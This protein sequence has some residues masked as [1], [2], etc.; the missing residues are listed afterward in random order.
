MGMI[1][2]TKSQLET[3]KL[4]KMVVAKLENLKTNGAGVIALEGELGAGKTTLVKGLAKELKIKEKVKSPTFVLVKNYKIPNSEL[5]IRNRI[6]NPKSVI[7]QFKYL[8][9]ID[10]YRLTNYKDLVALGI[11][12][13][14]KEEGSIIAIEW[15]ERVKSI[16]PKKRITVRIDHADKNKRAIIIY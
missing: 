16:L 11:K 9:H 5:R 12:D 1:F 8:Y 13:M 10:C 4:A 7:G 14:F 6:R 3:I 15:S 2:K